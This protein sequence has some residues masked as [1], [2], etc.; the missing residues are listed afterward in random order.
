MLRNGF[1]SHERGDPLAEPVAQRDQ[2]PQWAVFVERSFEVRE[3]GRLV[4]GEQC[5]QGLRLERS[6]LVFEQSTRGSIGVQDLS[7]VAVECD[8]QH[9]L[10][11]RLYRNARTRGDEDGAVG[12]DHARH[13]TVAHEAPVAP[14]P[15]PARFEVVDLAPLGI[16]A[17]E[18]E[19]AKRAVSR[20]R[21]PRSLPS[22]L[23]EGLR[24][25]ELRPTDLL[26]ATAQG[27]GRLVLDASEPPVDVGLP[28]AHVAQAA[29]RGELEFMVDDRGFGRSDKRGE[30]VQ[31]IG[32]RFEHRVSGRAGAPAVFPEGD[33]RAVGSQARDPDLQAGPVTPGDIGKPGRG[34]RAGREHQGCPCRHRGCRWRRRDSS[35]V[36]VDSI[37]VRQ[38]AV[39]LHVALGHLRRVSIQK[40]VERRQHVWPKQ[41]HQRGQRAR[42]GQ[43]KDES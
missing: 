28:I 40:I 14:E 26:G 25:F 19:V 22:L 37:F 31:C 17:F 6:G 13:A 34:Q 43:R 39:W 7:V 15:R 3:R 36:D 20:N 38:R 12:G 8:Q 18:R 41:Q 29:H 4:I 32:Q 11:T 5:L 42:D 1:E 27:P 16:G 10:G 24:S 35:R 21:F 2:A 33:A 23:V 9:R 30:S